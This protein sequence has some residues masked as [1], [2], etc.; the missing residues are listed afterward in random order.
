[1][2]ILTDAP[3]ALTP[4]SFPPNTATK[5][6]HSKLEEAVMAEVI[7]PVLP[8]AMVDKKT[9]YYINPTGPIRNPAVPW[10]TQV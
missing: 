8:G 6:S 2:N 3:L 4:W 7:S 1:L 10:V 5:V 9:K